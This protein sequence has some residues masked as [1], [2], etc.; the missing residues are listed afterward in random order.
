ML[1]LPAVCRTKS[2]YYKHYLRSVGIGYTYS[3]NVLEG[4]GSVLRATT[5][6][7]YMEALRYSA[8]RS[9]FCQLHVNY[10]LSEDAQLHV[11]KV[12]EEKAAELLQVLPADSQFR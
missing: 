10:S 1:A 12:V 2:I 11:F 8:V 5:Q 7:A 3:C 4:S 6:L 9:S